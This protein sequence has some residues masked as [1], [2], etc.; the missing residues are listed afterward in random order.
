MKNDFEKE[1]KDYSE[2][3]CPDIWDRIEAGLVDRNQIKQ[4]D[5]KAKIALVRDEKSETDEFLAENLAEKEPQKRWV[6]FA[7]HRIMPVA[8]VLMIGVIGF[9]FYQRFGNTLSQSDLSTTRENVALD[10]SAEERM[11]DMM[12]DESSQVAESDET[13]MEDEAVVSDEA[14]AAGDMAASESADASSEN[15]T[16]ENAL[17]DMV[18]SESEEASSDKRM[19]KNTISKL[20]DFPDSEKQEAPMQ[21]SPSPETKL[22]K[23]TLSLTVGKTA[24]LK[25]L[26][27]IEN[28]IPGKEWK[29]QGLDACLVFKTEEGERLCVYVT[30]QEKDTILQQ[31]KEQ[32]AGIGLTVQVT[33]KNK[34]GFEAVLG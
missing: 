21:I 26:Q 11:E 6:N 17:G 15:D 9:G 3:T 16:K 33:G 13:M 32:E 7:I 28:K 8:A 31:V 23:D 25:N 5:E 4:Q 12:E 2:Q 18:M 27:F 14:E 22:V 10:E 20:D 30:L 1:Y 29:K 24:Q 19:E 34:K